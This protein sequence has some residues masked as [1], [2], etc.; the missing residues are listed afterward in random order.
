MTATVSR[1]AAA[2]VST[3]RKRVRRAGSPDELNQQLQAAADLKRQIDALELQLQQHRAWLLTHLQRSGDSA[4]TL[5][6]FTAALRSRASWE[7]SP[8]L[9]H[10]ALRLKNEQQLEQRDG[11]AINTPTEYVA[12]TFKAK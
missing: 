5:G 9:H 6:D 12:L 3:R 8:R 1:P 11:T 4:V 7:Y 10:E 2:T